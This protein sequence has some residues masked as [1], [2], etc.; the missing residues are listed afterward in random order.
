MTTNKFKIVTL[1]CKVNQHESAYIRDSLI[2]SGYNEAAK[3]EQADLIVINTCIVTQTASSQSRQAIRKAIK[4]NPSSTTAAVGCYAQVFPEELT[5]IDGI[6]II[7]GN[8]EKGRLINILQDNSAPCRPCAIPEKFIKPMPF[9]FLP[10][11][12]FLDRTRAFIKI[13]DGCES[14]CSY[15]IVPYARGPLRSLDPSLVIDSLK[16][17]ADEGYKEVVLSGIHLGKYGIDQKESVSLNGLLNLIGREN[18]GPRIRLSS[19]EPNEIDEELIDMISS[20]E[21]LCSHLHIPLHSGNGGILRRMN[22]HYSP[23]EFAK[24]AELIHRKIPM[25]AIGADVIAGFPGE[26]DQAH[27]DTCSMIRNLPVSYLHVF[28]FS[29][30]KGTPAAEF[31]DQTGRRQVKE[32]AAELRDLGKKKRGIFNQSCIGKE[33]SILTEGWESGENNRIKGLSDN[34]LSVVFP[35]SELITNKIVKVR[36]ETIQEDRIIGRPKWEE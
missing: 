13:Q 33:F 20:E 8:T 35:S 19:L 2:A 21:W 27:Q 30:R 5:P 9:E 10:I 34:Y 7:A 29:P 6:N 18:L 3:N 16:S 36:I 12:G 1:G 28:P 22:R 26:D 4:E 24:L 15:C 25:A 17:L 32:R 31:S 11:K 23:E 14:F